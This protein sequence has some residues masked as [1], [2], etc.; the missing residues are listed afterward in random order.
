[1][2]HDP[3]IE[4]LAAGL[5]QDCTAC[6]GQPTVAM[7]AARPWDTVRLDCPTLQAHRDAARTHATAITE[8]GWRILRFEPVIPM[9]VTRTE[10]IA[11]EWTP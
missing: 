2:T 6:D 8:A 7:A 4:V 1:M 10:R 3:L 11:G 9:M 5:H